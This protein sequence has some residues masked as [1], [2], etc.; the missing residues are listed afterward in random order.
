MRKIIP[1][2]KEIKFDNNLYEITSIS[3]EHTLHRDDRNIEGSFIISG[4]YRITESSSNT[5]E[6]YYDLPFAID[7]DDKYNIDN[8]DIDINDFY[9][10]ILDNKYLVINIEVKLDHIEEILMERKEDVMDINETEEV[11]ACVEEDIIEPEEER[12]FKE[13]TIKEEKSKEIKIEE[14]KSLFSNMDNDNYVT[15]KVYIVRETDSIESIINKY[16][17]TKED[18]ELYND[19]SEIKIG[20]KIIIPYVKN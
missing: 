14:V 6:F 15:Y 13:Q 5:L 20:D 4:E 16:Q 12:V 9:Y 19:I 3:L 8:V 11:P 17:V 2:K 10:E 1:F 7:I 18:I